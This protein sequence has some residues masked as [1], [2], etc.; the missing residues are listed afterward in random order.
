MGHPATNDTQRRAAI[1]QTGTRPLG[2][3]SVPV[4]WAV[5]SAAAFGVVGGVIGLVVGLS[6]NPPTAWFAVLEV[7][8]PAAFVG[9]WV[10]L[11]I[12]GVASLVGHRDRDIVPRPRVEPRWRDIVTSAVVTLGALA[13]LSALQWMDWASHDDGMNRTTFTGGPTRLL[14]CAAL[15]S[16]VLSVLI[17]LARRRWLCLLLLTATLLTAVTVV[18]VALSRI[19]S[20]NS[21]QATGFSKTSYESGAAVGILAALVMV[22]AAAGGVLIAFAQPARPT[23]GPPM[24]PTYSSR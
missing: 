21:F 9:A 13:V 8:F 17:A 16:F 12:G 20:A 7:G 24:A 1:A 5:T 10:G 3:L 19:A 6:A 2:G 15:A 14:A 4:R 18:L 23:P 11:F 22:A